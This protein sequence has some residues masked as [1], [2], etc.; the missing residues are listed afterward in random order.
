MN[1]NDLKFLTGNNHY[2]D[3]HECEV[4]TPISSF[5]LVNLMMKDYWKDSLDLTTHLKA[6][7]WIIQ[8]RCLEMLLFNKLNDK[9]FIRENYSNIN[10]KIGRSIGPDSVLFFQKYLKFYINN[11]KCNSFSTVKNSNN[12]CKLNNNK[13][14]INNSLTEQKIYQVINPCNVQKET[15]DLNNLTLN[16]LKELNELNELKELTD[17][18]NLGKCSNKNTNKMSNSNPNNNGKVFKVMKKS[19]NSN[20]LDFLSWSLFEQYIIF[21]V[22]LIHNSN[23]N[24]LKKHLKGKSPN[25]AKHHFYYEV[26]KLKSFDE[27]V[28][29]WLYKS[30]PEKAAFIASKLANS[31][32]SELNI[33]SL[34]ELNTYVDNQLND[35]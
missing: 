11:Y 5:G 6:N 23:W 9:S 35:C 34:E 20:S 30:I 15:P 19:I 17:K 32:M 21:R 22:Y 24:L 3:F 29:Y 16:E 7:N 13:E 8:L 28:N 4:S 26:K 10:Q 18:S 25:Q 14:F 1:E 2:Q 33:G 27:N 12:N 31:L